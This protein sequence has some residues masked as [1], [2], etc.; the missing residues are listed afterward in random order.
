MQFKEGTRRAAVFIPK[1][2]Q[3]VPLG[4]ELGGIS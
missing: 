2:A 3:N 4:V 1:M